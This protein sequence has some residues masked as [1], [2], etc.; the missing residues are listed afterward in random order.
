VGVWL[1][2]ERVYISV[3]NLGDFAGGP[4]ELGLLSGEP[5]VSPCAS[6]SD[7]RNYPKLIFSSPRAWARLTGTG[8]R[9][10]QRKGVD[11]QS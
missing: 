11:G 3:G 4:T 6:L 5:H 7:K 9:R 10:R 8:R 1:D 2:S